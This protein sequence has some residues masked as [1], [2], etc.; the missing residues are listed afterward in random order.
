MRSGLPSS[1]CGPKTVAREQATI[2]AARQTVLV[3]LTDGGK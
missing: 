3:L 2:P 1:D